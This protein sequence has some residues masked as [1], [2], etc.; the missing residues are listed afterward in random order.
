ME[1][2]AVLLISLLPHLYFKCASLTNNYNGHIYSY[3]LSF[4]LLFRVCPDVE[5]F[6]HLTSKL[7]T[8]PFPPVEW[9]VYLSNQTPTAL[10]A[11]ESQFLPH[12]RLKSCHLSICLF[13]I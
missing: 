2:I 9:K 8:A 5:S 13:A 7:P 6:L 1:H 12:H 3:I 11:C 4:S 10:P